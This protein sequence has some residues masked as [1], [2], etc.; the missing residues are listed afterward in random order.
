MDLG[1]KKVAATV[2]ASGSPYAQLEGHEAP[3]GH[4]A[5]NGGAEEEQWARTGGGGFR[6]TQPAAAA[7]GERRLVLA[8]QAGVGGGAC[9]VADLEW[10]ASSIELLC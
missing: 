7:D 9:P 10:P 3:S 5:R 2:G 8:W 4:L 1:S 6:S